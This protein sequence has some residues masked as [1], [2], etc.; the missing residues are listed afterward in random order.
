MTNKCCPLIIGNLTLL[1]WLR[2]L[3][4]LVYC[5]FVV[6][7]VT[8]LFGKQ[9]SLLLSSPYLLLHTS[10]VFTMYFILRTTT[11]LKSLCKKSI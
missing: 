10:T 2:W 4:V 5:T 3:F 11:R 8:G 9:Y 7:S 1:L 6:K